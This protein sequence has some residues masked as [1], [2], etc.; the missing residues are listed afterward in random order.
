MQRYLALSVQ[1]VGQWR[2][3]VRVLGDAA[4]AHPHYDSEA[5]RRLEAARIDGAIARWCAGRDAFSAA[6]ELRAAGV[7]AEAV[8][9]P[10]DLYLDAQL[11]HRGHFVQLRHAAMG[12]VAFDGLQAHFSHAIH[13]P[14]SAAPTLGQHTREVLRE[15]LGYP[16]HEIDRLEGMGVLR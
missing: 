16:D 6:A 10:S 1:E 4:L 8:L 11:N 13:G 12:E 15:V 5:L 2:G 14:F 9:R 7:P 3:L